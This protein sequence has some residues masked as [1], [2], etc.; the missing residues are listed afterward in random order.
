MS[1]DGGKAVGLLRF[2]SAGGGLP[3]SQRGERRNMTAQAVAAIPGFR[4]R[5]EFACAEGVRLAEAGG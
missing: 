3:P 4:G 1:D 2:S 5:A